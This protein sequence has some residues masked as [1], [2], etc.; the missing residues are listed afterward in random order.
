MHLTRAQQLQMRQMAKQQRDR[1]LSDTK[2]RPDFHKPITM[3]DVMREF[4]I[5]TYK[6]RKY[7]E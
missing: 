6:Q 5:N 1:I 2:A 7:D 4:S 3:G